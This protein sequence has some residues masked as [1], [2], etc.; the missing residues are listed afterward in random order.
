MTKTG[1]FGRLSATLD[2]KTVLKIPGGGLQ[3]RHPV[4]QRPV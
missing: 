1:D 3:T 2:L 4:T